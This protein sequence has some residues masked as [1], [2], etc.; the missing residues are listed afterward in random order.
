MRRIAAFLPVVFCCT[1]Y[2]ADTV[3][4]YFARGDYAGALPALEAARDAAEHAGRRDPEVASVLNNLGTAYTELG[5]SRDA[6]FVFE[7]SLA[8][9]R[10]AGEIATPAVA[11]TLNNLGSVYLKLGVFSKA[12]ETLERASAIDDSNSDALNGARVWIALGS[13]Y[14]AEHRW[15]DAEKQFRKALKVREQTLGPEHRDTAAALNNL[16]VFLQ[17]RHRPEEAEPV[18]T[19]AMKIWR[20]ELGPMHPWVAAVLNN[21]GVLYAA[22]HRVEDAEKNFKEAIRIGDAALPANHPDLASFK[23]SYAHLL[24]T[25]GRK[26]QARKLEESARAARDANQRENLLGYTVDAQRLRR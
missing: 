1:I 6:Q 11:A 7:R 22:L 5:R 3:E 20:T 23:L 24:R 4:E 26:E 13:V 15:D 2:A 12:E 17:L 8:M 18:L 9:R 25:S 10:D 16:G 21:L 19:R 14:E